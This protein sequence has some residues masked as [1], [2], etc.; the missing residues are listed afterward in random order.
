MSQLTVLIVDSFVKCVGRN[1]GR[2]LQF[3][4]DWKNRGKLHGFLV[5]L[6][7]HVKTFKSFLIMIKIS[8]V[9]G[10]LFSAHFDDAKFLI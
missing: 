6:T 8:S 5:M 2:Y 10:K 7:S 3:I 1:Q 4:I 9:S